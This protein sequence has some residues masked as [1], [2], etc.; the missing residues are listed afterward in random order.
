MEKFTIIDIN[1]DPHKYALDNN[2]PDGMWWCIYK[3]THYEFF[4]IE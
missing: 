4:W 3:I 2:I 1:T